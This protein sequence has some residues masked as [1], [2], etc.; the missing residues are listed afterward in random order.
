M[1]YY[2]RFPGDYLRDTLSLTMAED[3]AYSRL[4]DHQYATESA[5]LDE[6]EA[7]RV[8]RARTKSERKIVQNVL[9]K[10]FTLTDNG[11]VNA[12][13]EKELTRSKEISSKRQEAGQLGGQK[14]ANAKQMPS[15]CFASQKPVSQKPEKTKTIYAW[16]ENFPFLPAMEEYALANGIENP[17]REF[18]LWKDDCLAHDRR[19]SDWMAAWRTRVNNFEK[20]NGGQN[21]TRE[22]F[23]ERN[24]RKSQDAI[25]E[26]RRRANEV[27][28]EVVPCLPES[29]DTK[30]HNSGLPR[31][32]GRPSS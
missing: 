6:T 32:V 17:R 30:G 25:S 3:G 11:W 10:F 20:F 23:A 14:K 8:A 28:S 19:Y 1:D 2:R 26:V 9:L 13:F 16:P 31:G 21:G 12:R 5:I 15:N 24:Q 22:S 27:L 29:S 7:Y 4:L 18:D